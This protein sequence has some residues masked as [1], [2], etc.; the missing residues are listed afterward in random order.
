MAAISEVNRSSLAAPASVDAYALRHGLETVERT[1]IRQVLDEIR[2]RPIL[3]LGVGGGRT[4]YDLHAVSSDY[5]AI[6]S[7]PEMVSA[8]RARYPD[9]DVRLG[10]ARDLSSLPRDH[11][12]FVLFSC[13]GIGMLGHPDRLRV[14]SEVLRVL[15]PGGVF[16]FSTH[17]LDSP[18]NHRAFVLPE[19]ELAL[20]PLR[21][22]VRTWR[23]A[24][25]TITRAFNRWKHLRHEEHHRGWSLLNSAC[26]DYDTL[27]YHVTMAEAHRQLIEAGYAHSI[28]AFDHRGV[29]IDRATID[30]SIFFVARRPG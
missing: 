11:F 6:D 1:V 24:R 26:L 27:L 7:M 14:L 20:H 8:C 3:D 12:A 30:D 18:H 28:R 23:F 2:G 21:N 4:T 9:V 16:A 22:A 17:N 13:N 29:E 10:D 5:V 15:A 25:R 19:L